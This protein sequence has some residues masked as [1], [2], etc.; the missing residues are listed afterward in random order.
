[1]KTR[2]LILVGFTFVS[3][4]FYGCGNKDSGNSQPPVQQ[5]VCPP[6][7][8]PAAGY[9]QTPYYG[10]QNGY[11]GQPNGYYNQGYYGQGYYGQQQGY[12]GQPQGYYGQQ[13]GY[14]GQ[15]NYGANPYGQ[16]GQL[17]CI[18]VQQQP[19][20]TGTGTG[21]TVPPPNGGSI[22]NISP[23]VR[24]AAYISVTNRSQFNLFLKQSGVCGTGA[25]YGGIYEC[26]N[27]TTGGYIELSGSGSTVNGIVAAGPYIGV[28]TD[29]A[30][31]PVNSTMTYFVVNAGQ[32]FE[33]RGVGM[34]AT[35]AYGGI[36]SIRAETGAFNGNQVSVVLSYRATGQAISTEFARAILQPN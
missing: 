12:Y 10:Q 14:Y 33:L 13:Q 26:N 21:Q 17:N 8:V 25:L 6:G 9:G 32:G 30:Y 16:T 34:G 1:M 31:L 4:L 36:L 15:P 3:G 11:Y 18:P 7:T 2:A 28:G 5:A 35:L 19:P 24:M 27:Y 20:T 22:G 29:G 23:A